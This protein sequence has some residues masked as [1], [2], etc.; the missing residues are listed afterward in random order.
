[1]ASLKPKRNKRNCDLTAQIGW[2][3]NF[4]TTARQ[5]AS[6]PTSAGSELPFAP[7]GG[8]E[9]AGQPKPPVGSNVLKFSRGSGGA[10]GGTGTRAEAALA[11]AASAGSA[12]IGIE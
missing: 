2:H 4:A 12:G 9:T 8:H 7:P 1:M 5:V 3:Q 11:S 6:A 10:V